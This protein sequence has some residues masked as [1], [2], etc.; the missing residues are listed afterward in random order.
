MLAARPVTGLTAHID[1]FVVGIKPIVHR[2]IAFLDVGAVALRTAGIP[3]KE[4]ARPV[5]WVSGCDVFVGVEVIPP[6]PA[7]AFGSGIPSDRE[8]LQATVTK[9]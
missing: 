3:V 6:L 4:S 1:L 7:F 5:Q 2:V 8:R 9:G